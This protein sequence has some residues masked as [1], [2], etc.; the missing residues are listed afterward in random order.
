ML[1]ASVEEAE[2]L[3]GTHYHIFSHKMSGHKVVR[4]LSYSIPGSLIDH[5]DVITPTTYFGTARA[6]R[7]TSFLDPSTKAIDD[8]GVFV[9]DTLDETASR[10]C[11]LKTTPSCLRALYKT[12]K[13]VPQSVHRNL[14]GIA[15]YLDEFVNYAD[16]SVSAEVESGPTL[17]NPRK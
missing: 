7:K 1:I 16:L 3:L 4:A 5:I 6:M 15:G 2:R 11:S 8:L 13:Y 9:G 14:L 10:R 12:A 17:S